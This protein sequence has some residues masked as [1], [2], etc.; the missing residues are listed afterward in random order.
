VERCALGELVISD[1]YVPSSLVYQ[2]IDCGEE[3][4]RLLNDPFPY[5]E[6]L[7]YIDIDPQIALG[8]LKKRPVKEVYEY[9]DFQM[10]VREGYLALIPRY[11]EAGVRV[12]VIDGSLP[13]GDAAEEVWRALSKVPIMGT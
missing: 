10:K 8:R 5:P 12:E 7:L 6:L 2:G 11:R 1:R 4:P 9:L 13:P 3:P